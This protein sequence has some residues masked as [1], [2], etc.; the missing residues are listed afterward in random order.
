MAYY[1]EILNG[2][3][4]M[5]GATRP[6]RVPASG[7]T[8]TPQTQPSYTP[9]PGE[10]D[11]IAEPPGA[12][13]PT[14]H[15]G[16]FK[17]R[18][19]DALLGLALGGPV[20][21]IAGLIS[22]QWTHNARHNLIDFPRYA[23]QSQL[24]SELQ[25]ERLQRI[26]GIGDLTGRIPG[27]NQPT[28]T[29]RHRLEQQRFREMQEKWN[30]FVERS[31][32]EDADL[33]RG[34]RGELAEANR[35]SRE[36]LAGN[37]LQAT[38]LRQGANNIIRSWA[39]RKQNL[40]PEARQ[41]L[42]DAGG[43]NPEY[44]SWV[45]SLQDEAPVG[46]QNVVVL[47]PQGEVQVME[48]PRGAGLTGAPQVTTVPGIQG[49]PMAD[50]Q[51]S[52][53]GPTALQIKNE[54]DQE[55]D[56]RFPKLK[57]EDVL[58]AVIFSKG[59]RKEGESNEAAMARYKQE[60]EAKRQAARAEIEGQVRQQLGVGSGPSVQVNPNIPTTGGLVAGQSTMEQNGKTY[61]YVGRNPITGK[62]RWKL[63]R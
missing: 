31:R 16:G 44:N 63:V 61:V 37:R 53:K 43:N 19:K 11:M 52:D 7:Q 25:S 55:L 30:Q 62:L 38:T 35:L 50:P 27:T 36:M 8:Q 17:S 9:I 34:Q 23:Q 21:G 20:G 13:H 5:R 46:I 6:R 45:D 29:A 57:D 12:P 51:G 26:R 15:S 28:E 3:M 41:Y 10:Q 33:A 59:F 47:G 4:A 48:L 22:P 56:R 2:V 49:K 18:L 42:K 54:V 58:A 14:Q 60:H 1:D 32:L 39:N 24:D 40:T